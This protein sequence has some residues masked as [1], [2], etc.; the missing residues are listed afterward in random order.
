MSIFTT[1]RN[2]FRKPPKDSFTLPIK[3]YPP[4][5]TVT[6]PLLDTG[7]MAFYLGLDART[8]NQ[9]EMSNGPIRPTVEWVNGQAWVRWRT[10][11]VR[12][13]AAGR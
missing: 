5:S 9:W 7:E 3:N 10:E 6:K 2:F 1:I 13:L 11:D 4:L 12:R 8:A